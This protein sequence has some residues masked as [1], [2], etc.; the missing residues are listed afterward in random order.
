MTEGAVRRALLL[1][2]FLHRQHDSETDGPRREPA[3]IDSRWQQIRTILDLS[4]DADA[5]NVSGVTSFLSTERLGWPQWCQS[6][7]RSSGTHSHCACGNLSQT[8]DKLRRKRSWIFGT[9]MNGTPSHQ[10]NTAGKLALIINNEGKGISANI[11][12][13][14]PMRWSRHSHEWSYCKNLNANVAAAIICI[15]SFAIDYNPRKA[16]IWNRKSYWLTAIIWLPFGEPTPALSK[17]CWMQ[18]C[19]LLQKLS[20]C[21]SFG[22]LKSSVSL[23]P[24]YARSAADLW[25]VQCSGGLCSED[26]TA[27]DYIERLAAGSIHPLH[28]VSVATSDL[29]EQWTRL[30][31]RLFESAR[32]RKT[33]RSRQ[34]TSIKRSSGERSKTAHATARSEVLRQYRNDGRRSNDICY[35]NRF[36]RNLDQN[37]AKDI[38]WPFLGWSIELDGT[39]ARQ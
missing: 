16:M 12:K 29:N 38:R 17:E 22:D 20:H 9:D 33:S 26:E 2:A 18:P 24:Q 39:V 30:C 21:A 13:T 34:G 7:Y 15:G 1:V 3:F 4:A 28:Q 19:V 6:F 10:W 8:L 14:S 25:G 37:W 32:V 31:S 36:D 27:D 5:T 11:K 35:L 23:M